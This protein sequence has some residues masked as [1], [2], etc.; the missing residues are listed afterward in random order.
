MMLAGKTNL[1]SATMLNKHKQNMP[2]VDWRHACVFILIAI[3]GL[4]ARQA[5]AFS[6][7]VAPGARTIFLQV[8]NGAQSN[9]ATINVV[10]VNV[11]AASIGNATP[12]VMTTNSTQAASTITGNTVCNVPSQ[13]YIAGALR[14]P[15]VSAAV[16]PLQVTAPANLT[17][18]TDTIAFS[19][20]SW[21]SSAIGGT[22]QDIPAGAFTGAAQLLVNVPANTWLENCHTFSYANTA[23]APAGVYTG[24][25]TYTLTAP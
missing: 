11:P 8:G 9:V 22:T 7:T 24:R 15:T 10:S 5:D 23:I 20:I 2:A 16:A 4:A 17:S 12:Q 3:T 25:V 13:I 19:Q 18:G 6:F 1:P 21:T 14:L